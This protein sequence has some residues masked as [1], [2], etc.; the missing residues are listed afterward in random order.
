MTQELFNIAAGIAGV[1]G[2]WWL[3]VMWESLRD[4]QDA[5]KQL[6]EKVSRIELFVAGNYV[7][8]DEFNRFL[9][10]I[11]DKLD[12]IENKLDSKVDK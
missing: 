9:G 2:G 4:L 11:Y 7:N 5:D 3:K 12:S 1:L 6:V 10:R 8:K